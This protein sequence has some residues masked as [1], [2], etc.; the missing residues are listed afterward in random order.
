M[1]RYKLNKHSFIFS[2]R[3]LTKGKDELDKVELFG[4]PLET[5][6]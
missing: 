5:I 1:L 6:L 3:S 4:L 2:S